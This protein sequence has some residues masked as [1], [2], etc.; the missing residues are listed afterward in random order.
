MI[1]GSEQLI[2]RV[3]AKGVA[4]LRPVEGDPHRSNIL[5]PVVGDIGERETVDGVPRIGVEKLRDHG[6]IL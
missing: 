1:E 5:G 3:G 4:Q 6:P 2:D